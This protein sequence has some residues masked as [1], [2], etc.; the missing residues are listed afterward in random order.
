MSDEQVQEPTPETET[1]VT[2]EVAP[3]VPTPEEQPA[4]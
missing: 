2:P 1:P 3:E 4:A